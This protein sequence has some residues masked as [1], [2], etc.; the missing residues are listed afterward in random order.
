MK[1]M[2][3]KLVVD[4]GVE[5]LHLDMRSYRGSKVEIIIRRVDD[6]KKKEEKEYLGYEEP[7]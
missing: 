5:D 7:T 6:A 2:E 1:K 4:S 3:T